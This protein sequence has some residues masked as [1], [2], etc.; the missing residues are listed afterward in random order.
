MGGTFRT[1]GTGSRPGPWV[2]YMAYLTARLAFIAWRQSRLPT[3]AQNNTFRTYGTDSRPG[4]WVTCIAYL[5]A[6][7]VRI[8]IGYKTESHTAA[9]RATRSELRVSMPW[10]TNWRISLSPQVAVCLYAMAVE[11]PVAITVHGWL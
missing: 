9:L 3:N 2:T 4:R 8:T 7:F 6:R 10:R 11:T 1:Y 5:T